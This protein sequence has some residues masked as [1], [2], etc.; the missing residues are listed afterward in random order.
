MLTLSVREKQGGPTEPA[1]GTFGEEQ[2]QTTTAGVTLLV[3]TSCEAH[4]DHFHCGPSFIPT[5]GSWSFSSL[6]TSVGKRITGRISADLVQATIKSGV[7]TPKAGGES[8][9]LRDL[10][11]D[12]V[13]AAP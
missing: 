10:V 4:E 12:A 6:G 13:L 11:V 1:D 9:C 2:L 8:L 5:A 7:A 3:Q